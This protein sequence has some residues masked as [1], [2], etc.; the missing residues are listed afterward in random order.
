MARTKATAE[1]AYS[2][3]ASRW[4]AVQSR[5]AVADGAFYYGVR[6]TGVYCRPSCPSRRP[7]REQVAFFEAPEDARRAGFRACLRCHPDNVTAEQL[8]VAK[9]LQLIE[10]SEAEPALGEL[11]DAVGLSASYLQRVFKRQTGLSPKQYAATLRQQ[12]FRQDLR[13]S[14]TVTDAVYEAGFG[15]TRGAYER[16]GE[17]LGMRPSV[18]RKGGLGERIS[19]AM[20]RTELGDM[21][22]AATPRG[23]CSVRFGS[24]TDL[25]SELRDEFP[26]AELMED[27]EA[28]KD[29]VRAVEER[30]GGIRL[31]ARGS[32]FQ[33]KVWAALR[34]I[35][36]GE[37]R[38]YSEVA[39]AI[40][41]PGAARAVARACA[42]NPLAL[43]TPCHRVVRADGGLGGYRWGIERKRA[44]LEL[45]GVAK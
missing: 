36:A 30:A 31:D 26:N 3:D 9:A 25:V 37:T 5:D 42:T 4:Q 16:A 44:L 20:A 38:T 40:G 6:S 8:A 14:K 34:E 19:Y 29:Y 33:Q 12:R 21:L 28:M 45:E 43:L 10:D 17:H 35:P 7:N 15:S 27:V 32:E 2:D 22:V 23:V 39:D 1:G 24:K 18:F 11:A 13:N 41:Q